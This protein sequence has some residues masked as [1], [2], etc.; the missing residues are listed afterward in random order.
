MINVNEVLGIITFLV[1]QIK[2]NFAKFHCTRI[3][4]EYDSNIT[5]V[6][7][8]RKMILNGSF[9]LNSKKCCCFSIYF[10]NE[11]DE[12][13]VLL[14]RVA[15]YQDNSLITTAKSKSHQLIVHINTHN[16]T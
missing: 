4:L 15:P 9:I 14:L 1:Q 7:K 5:S 6:I 16:G 12:I 13:K 2:V 11:I 10:V 3:L 8:N